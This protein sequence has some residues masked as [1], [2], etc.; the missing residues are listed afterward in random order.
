MFAAIAGNFA[1]AVVKFIAAAF[2]HSSAMLSEGIHSL[3]DMGNGGLLF[4]GMTKAEE[5][6]DGA[7]PFGHGK[8]LYFWSLI[9]AVS[10][11]GI[12]GGMSIYEGVI[13]IL[14]P[15]A[16]EDPT[17]AYVVLAIS[18]VIEGSSFLIAFREFRRAKGGQSTFHAIRHGKDPSLFTVVFEDSAALVGLT[19]AFLGVFF[20]HLLGS[21]YLDAT[22]S[23]LIGVLLASVALWLAAESKGLLIGE[24]A[25]DE[26]VANITRIVAADPCVMRVGPIL[27]VYNGPADLLLNLEVEFEPGLEAEEIRAAIDRIEP[28]IMERYPQVRRIFIEV[29]SLRPGVP[30]K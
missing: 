13:H 28:A 25:D 16:L 21:P 29:G 30:P 7:H 27:S 15:S 12:G 6:A 11:F 23:V 19:F 14:H 1:I 2:T 22:A 9:V 17:L 3:V 24:G 10:I 5:P 8:E 20:G 26:T 4:Y 18:A